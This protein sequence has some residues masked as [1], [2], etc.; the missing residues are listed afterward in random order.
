M[1]TPFIINLE[2]HPQ[3]YVFHS[4]EDTSQQNKAKKPKPSQPKSS[5]PKNTNR[6][7]K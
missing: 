1:S 4:I 7:I 6:L 5:L 3:G 2:R